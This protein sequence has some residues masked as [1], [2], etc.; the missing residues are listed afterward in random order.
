METEKEKNIPSTAPAQFTPRLRAVEGIKR[1]IRQNTWTI[2]Q[3]LPAEDTLAEIFSV[4]RSTIR[5]RKRTRE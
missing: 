4:S 3:R 5:K 2:G 1:L